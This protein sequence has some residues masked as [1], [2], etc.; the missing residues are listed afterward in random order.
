MLCERS[1]RGT[2]QWEAWG[3]TKKKPTYG[4]KSIYD[5][6]EKYWISII[7]HFCNVPYRTYSTSTS[8]K[9]NIEDGGKGGGGFFTSPPEVLDPMV[10]K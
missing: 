1:L 4:T 2:T 6:F 8:I 3:G 10:R 5:Q 9:G 7:L